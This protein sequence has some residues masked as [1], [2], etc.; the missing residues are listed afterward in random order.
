MRALRNIAIIVVLAL[1][2]SV[3][4]AGG[5]V[6]SGVLAALSLVFIGVIGLLIVR[7]WGQASFT[8]DTLT[9]RQ[10]WLLYASLGAIALMIAGLDEMFDTGVG[11][12][13]WLAVVA[14]SGWAV[15]TTWRE[16]RSF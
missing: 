1:A 14:L 15:F 10:R 2:I 7:F 11:T 3:L 13:V 9:E 16:A 4:P 12:V 5:N 8:L 6:A